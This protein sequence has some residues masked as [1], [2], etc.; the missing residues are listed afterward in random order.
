MVENSVFARVLAI[1]LATTF[2]GQ[3]VFADEFVLRDGRTIG[4]A[5]K[6]TN[7]NN[8]TKTKQ[9]AVEV[10][11]G[12]VVRVNSSEVKTHKASGA[13][14]AEYVAAMASPMDTVAFHL[15]VAAWCKANGL[16]HHE[17]AHY[18]RAIELEPDNDLAR[19]ALKFVRGKDG[20]WVKIEQ[21]QLEER[22]KVSVGGRFRFP[23]VVAIEEVQETTKNERAALAAKIVGWQR[24]VL[25]NNRRAADSQTKLQTLDGPYASLALSDIL[26]PKSVPVRK[27]PPPESMRRIYVDVLTRLADPVAIQ[28]LIRMSLN[29]GSIAVRDLCLDQLKQLAP[30]AATIAYIQALRSDKVDEINAAGRALAAMRDEVAIMP[31][32]ERVVSKHKETIPGS[33]ATN[34][35]FGSGSDGGTTLGNAKPRV[36]DRSS[37]NVDVLGALVAITG[38]NFQYDRVAWLNWYN[39]KYFGAG[40]DLRRDQ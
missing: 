21:Q 31:L 30:R 10:A 5:V 22:G 9:Y 28:T 16:P 29:D 38:Q 35:G 18:E 26:F 7:S 8:E 14:E 24:D 3:Q 36:I 2:L 13:H 37:N 17:L 20:R 32:I 6:S 33:S 19:A 39:E 40:R 34:V 1:G 4:G 11:S 27:Q 12:V 25:E 15:K 23:E